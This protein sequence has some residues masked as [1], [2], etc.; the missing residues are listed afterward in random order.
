MVIFDID[1][2]EKEIL[3]VGYKNKT[4]E[5]KDKWNQLNIIDIQS[6]LGNNHHLPL[7]HIA[8]SYIWL[9]EKNQRINEFS[10]GYIMNPNLPKR[11]AFREQV[12]LCL[13]NIFVPST[14]THIGKI[15]L[16]DNTR[17]LALVVFYENSKINAR[18]FLEC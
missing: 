16:K 14:I 4:I 3:T 17:V 18:K 12:K 6:L 9:E 7:S 1:N 5:N 2:R 8:K 10:I 13:K 15:L 11:K